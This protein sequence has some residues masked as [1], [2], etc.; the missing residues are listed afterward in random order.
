GK[1]SKLKRKYF[2]CEHLWDFDRIPASEGIRTEQWKYFRYRDYPEHEELYDL[3]KDPM[4]INN[5]AKN[6]NYRKVL[7]KMRK[8]LEVIIK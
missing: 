8:K 1:K 5:L 2:H 4:E 6:P 7:K 3:Q